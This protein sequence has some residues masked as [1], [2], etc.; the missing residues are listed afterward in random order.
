MSSAAAIEES[1]ENTELFKHVELT[2]R[3]WSKQIERALVQYQQL[4][5]ENEFVGPLVEIEYWRRQLA[6]FT[7]IVEFIR[8]EQCNGYI[9]CLSHSKPK[10]VKVI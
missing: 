1:L 3:T 2:V 5:R 9:N 7:S 8:T 10:V 6:R 4:R